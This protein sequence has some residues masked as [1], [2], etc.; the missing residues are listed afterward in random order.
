MPWPLLRVLDSPGMGV[1]VRGMK[2]GLGVLAFYGD[3]W[4]KGHNEISPDYLKA[5]S[6][7]WAMG[8]T[9]KEVG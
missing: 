9:G 6:G 2:D 7:G 1:R 3:W 5:D 4:T 8:E